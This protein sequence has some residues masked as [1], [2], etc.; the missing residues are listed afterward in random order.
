MSKY[1]LPIDGLV[2]F[3]FFPFTLLAY[4]TINVWV[5]G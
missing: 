1:K 5:V 4:K 3:M 2:I